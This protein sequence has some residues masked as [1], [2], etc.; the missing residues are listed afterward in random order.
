MGLRWRGTKQQRSLNFF[1]G[2][3]YDFYLL[4]EYS[5]Q[6]VR[7]SEAMKQEIINRANKKKSYYFCLNIETFVSVFCND[8]IVLLL[9]K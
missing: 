1:S 7:K 5:S 4:I 3:I 9:L 6:N 2:I 8:Q